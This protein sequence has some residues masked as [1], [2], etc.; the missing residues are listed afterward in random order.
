MDKVPAKL[1]CLGLMFGS[2]AAWSAVQAGD[3]ATR[4]RSDALANLARDSAH[5]DQLAAAIASTTPSVPETDTHAA[6]HRA[7]TASSSAAHGPMSDGAAHGAPRY[8]APDAVALELPAPTSTSTSTT[9]TT[10][11]TATPSVDEVVSAQLEAISASAHGNRAHHVAPDA[12]V[13]Q[14][15]DP[16]AT[17]DA[18]ERV[19][20]VST[21]VTQGNEVAA[22]AAQKSSTPA[23]ASTASNTSNASNASNAPNAPNASMISKTHAVE[24]RMRLNAA[25]LTEPPSPNV[26]TSLGAVSVASADDDAANASTP[27]TQAAQRQVANV[28]P[29]EGL[30]GIKIEPAGLTFAK[31][32]PLTPDTPNVPTLP[33]TTD[34]LP[35]APAGAATARS[36]WTLSTPAPLASNGKDDTAPRAPTQ[37]GDGSKNWTEMKVSDAR[38]DEMRG[39]FD[40]ATGLQIAF[41]IERAVF[42]NG[43]LVA[44]TSF[45]IPNLAQITVPQAQQLAQALNSATIVQTGA[46]NIAPTTILPGSSAATIIQNTLNNQSIKALTTVNAAVNTLAQFKAS[47]VQSTINSAIAN[48]I[49]PR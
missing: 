43:Q 36:A 44:V 1:A 22:D 4:P 23:V 24:S 42:V 13:I 47:N 19:A 12:V 34:P 5:L 14:F 48:T 8:V 41:G 3:G 9:T 29:A 6:H 32:T 37:G 18:L 16:R 2:G 30:A 40:I 39:G 45:N 46:G 17:A 31:A 27:T 20:P 38:L 49:L 28:A 33:R 21:A 15:D 35:L 11:T 25:R 7:A 10:T 26:I